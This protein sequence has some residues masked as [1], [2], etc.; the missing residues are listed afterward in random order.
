MKDNILDVAK[1][2]SIYNGIDL[3]GKLLQKL[4]H[5][6]DGLALKYTKNGD[7]MK[8]LQA[9]RLNLLSMKLNS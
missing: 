6:R 1:E 7:P 4:G 3:H 8:Y 2:A 5:C 9:H